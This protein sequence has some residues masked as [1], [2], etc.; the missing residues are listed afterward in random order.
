ML[1]RH[2]GFHCGEIRE[3]CSH[4]RQLQFPLPLETFERTDGLVGSVFHLLLN[5]RINGVANE[6]EKRTRETKN[7]QQGSDKELGS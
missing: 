5:L 6:I 4:A 1:R 7:D 3:H 2:Q